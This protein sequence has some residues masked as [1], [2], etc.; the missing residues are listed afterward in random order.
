[1]EKKSTFS[2]FLLSFSLC[3][4]LSSIQK[5]FTPRAFQASGMT[6]SSGVNSHMNLPLK[7]CTSA[8]KAKHWWGRGWG[9]FAA[10]RCV[11]R[12]G[13]FWVTV[14]LRPEDERLQVRLGRG[15]RESRLGGCCRGQCV[16]TLSRCSGKQ[17]GPEAG[18]IA[19]SHFLLPGRLFH[20]ALFSSPPFL[21]AFLAPVVLE[22]LPVPRRWGL[23]TVPCWCPKYHVLTPIVHKDVLGATREQRQGGY[24]R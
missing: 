20:S 15:E 9:V 23:L 19:L 1:M 4:V 7:I 11:T 24:L 5:P 10:L 16:W 13:F 3:Q 14:E 8:R 12:K 21:L 22:G 2:F 17:A 6:A 18:V